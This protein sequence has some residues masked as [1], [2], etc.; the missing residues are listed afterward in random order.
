VRR[1]RLKLGG[2]LRDSVDS[3]RFPVVT[4]SSTAQP[5]SDRSPSS[6][7]PAPAWD[8]PSHSPPVFVVPRSQSSRNLFD[9]GTTGTSAA[10]LTLART[11]V[12]PRPTLG[13]YECVCPAVV[14]LGPARG[15]V[16]KARMWLCVLEPR[17][18]PAAAV[19]PANRQLWQG[20]EAG[21]VK[22]FD[23]ASDGAGVAPLLDVPGTDSPWLGQDSGSEVSLR[24][25]C[26][27]V[28]TRC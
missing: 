1:L 15:R 21:D 6:L 7:N 28:L 9:D 4:R 23:D 8:T 14:S 25:R 17:L 3:S 13:G 11:P 19:P 20:E 12:P 27:H 26:Q 2:P 24:R 16:L 22:L 5:R 10:P 18:F